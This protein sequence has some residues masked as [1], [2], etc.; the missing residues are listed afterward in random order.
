MKYEIGQVCLIVADED[1][2]EAE[3]AE[4]LGT[5]GSVGVLAT[6]INCFSKPSK[7]LYYEVKIDDV[8]EDSA[9]YDTWYV[10]HHHLQPLLTDE[11][12]KQRAVEMLG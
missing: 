2:F 1:D 9:H 3:D 7:G 6:I 11:E 4:A 5:H 10:W 8:D 12:I